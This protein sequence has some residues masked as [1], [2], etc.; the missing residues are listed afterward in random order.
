MVLYYAIFNPE[1][2]QFN[3]SFPDLSELFTSGDDMSD[4]LH[5]AK[6]ALEGYLLW[7]EDEKEAFPPASEYD[8]ISPSKGDLLIPIEANLEVA[9]LK[10]NTKMIKKTLTIPNYVNAL[11][12]KE[13]INFSQ[14]L[15]E[16]LKEKLQIH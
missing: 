9:R 10:E 16:V 6:D 11:A 15:T 12:E 3:V 13:G 14:T 1:G 4:A 7:L 8:E 2:T 5:M